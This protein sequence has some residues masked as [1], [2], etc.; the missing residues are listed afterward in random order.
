M[1]EFEDS[2]FTLSESF[3]LPSD[4]EGRAYFGDQSPVQV[5]F[6]GDGVWVVAVR[7][8]FQALEKVQTSISEQ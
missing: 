1:F 2:D 6:L 8:D 3:P 4:E 7:S 5:T